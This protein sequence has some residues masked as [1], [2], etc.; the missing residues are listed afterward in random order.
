MSIDQRQTV[1]MRTFLK[2][3][4]VF[5][6]GRS[7]MD[8]LVRDMSGTGAR[9]EL[10]ETTTLPEAFDLYIQNKDQTYRSTLRWRRANG[11][12]VTFDMAAKP[13][14]ALAREV[15]AEPAAADPSMTMLVRRIT[16]LEA[17]NAALRSVIASMGRATSTAA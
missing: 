14:P 9:L 7:T 11:V 6:N 12:G 16:E 1:R 8:C 13:A 4:I 3:K 15:V 17:E 10:S 2:G 5:N